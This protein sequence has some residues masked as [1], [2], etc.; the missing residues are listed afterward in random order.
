M[1]G[2]DGILSSEEAID[3]VPDGISLWECGSTGDI[4]GKANGDYEKRVENPLG[5]DKSTSTFVFV[6]PREWQGADEWLQNHQ[7]EWKKVVVYT[8]VE[9]EAWIEKCPSVGMWL[10]F[11]LG[12]LPSRGYCLPEKYWRDW[13]TGENVQLPPG[14]VLSDRSAESEKIIDKCLKPSLVNV[15]AFTQS[16]AMAFVIATLMKSEKSDVLLSRSVVATE[17]SAYDDLTEHYKN[18]IIITGLENVCHTCLENGHT[19]IRAVT[20]A[21]QETNV[22]RLPEIGIDGFISGLVECGIDSVKARKLAHDTAK[23]VNI[24]RRRENIGKSKPDWVDQT[25]LSIILPAVLLGRWQESNDGDKSLVE[26]MAGCPYDEYSRKLKPLLLLPDTPIDIIGSQVRIKAPTDV[27][28]LV[29]KIISEAELDR[30][31]DICNSLISDD[32]PDAVRNTEPESFQPWKFEQKYSPIIKEGVYQTLIL[33]SLHSSDIC[34]FN[35]WVDCTVREMLKGWDYKRMLSNRHYLLLLAE[36][37][38]DIFMSFVENLDSDL[39]KR[40]LTPVKQKMSLVGCE[41]YYTELLFALEMLAW[42]EDYILRVSSLLM[43]YTAVKNDSNYANRPENSLLR[44]FQFQLPQTYATYEQRKSVLE[45]LAHKYPEP[46]FNLCYQLLVNIDRGFLEENHYYRWRLFNRINS[47]KYI[48][49]IPQQQV[50]DCVSIMLNSCSY[51]KEA[52]LKLIPLSSRIIMSCARTELLSAIKAHIGQFQGDYDVCKTLRDDIAHNMSC[53]DAKWALNEK[54]LAPYRDLL[55]YVQPQDPL[56]RNK[57]MFDDPYLQLPIRHERDW[58]KRHNE[59]LLFRTNGLRE[60]I[61]GCGEDGVWQLLA[62]AGFPESVVDCILSIY[63]DGWTEKFIQKYI[64]CVIPERVL[65]RYFSNLFYRIGEENYILLSQDII[66]RGVTGLSAL[67]LYAPGYIRSLAYIVQSVTDADVSKTYWKNVRFLF[68]I[69]DDIDSIINKLLEVERWKD[70]VELVYNNLES[71]LFDDERIASIL[72]EAIMT[73]KVIQS[74]IEFI[75]ITTILKHLDKSEN[76]SVVGPVVRIEFI[77]YDALKHRM[78][79]Y[80]SRL[81]KELMNNPAQMMEIITMLY[82]DDEGKTIADGVSDDNHVLLSTCAFNILFDLHRSPCT[83]D[84]GNV[85]ETAL[86]EYIKELLRL[87]KERGYV[88]A[89]EIVTGDLLGCLPRDEHYPHDVLCELVEQLASDTVD[90]HIRFRIINNRGVTIRAYNEGGAQERALVSEFSI[91][92]DKAKFK[93][94][95][96]T[97]IFDDIIADYNNQA[98]REDVEAKLA[99][100]G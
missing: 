52:I 91:Y 97:R 39:W 18:L 68:A 49:A 98:Y 27:L 2:W 40:F 32:D 63:G 57:W 13:A 75:Y 81:M 60:I 78:N 9:L 84:D 34:H 79:I 45:T 20:P 72:H 94:P 8:A 88:K 41:I 70:A 62:T 83:D 89:T 50:K 12:I 26:K 38:P 28:P 67:V 56:L 47:P 53:P 22:I 100:L 69:T 76:P 54:E 99:E 37:A 86:K 10:A 7:G 85:N 3:V 96:L 93:S 77:L 65:V 1:P 19:V 42:D 14:I 29:L 48:Y 46:V 71:Q 59:V 35:E 11:V 64:E 95:R 21:D 58:E 33:L 90:T 15:E 55:E 61:A 5:Y 44:L 51:S 25:N 80:K 43:K 24:L 36:A 16:E 4:V 30:L 73:G 87:A 66:S 92:K 31:K 23:D 17:Q 82:K 6:T 74:G